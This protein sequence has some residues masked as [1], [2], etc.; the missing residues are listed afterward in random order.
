[1][2]RLRAGFASAVVVLASAALPIALVRADD[3]KGKNGAA[4]GEPGRQA[5]KLLQSYR[6]FR[7]RSGEYDRTRKEIDQQIKELEELVRIRYDMTLAVAELKACAGPSKSAQRSSAAVGDDAL[8]RELKA[9]QTQ[10]A[11]EIEQAHAQTEKVAAQLQALKDGHKGEE[12]KHESPAAARPAANAK[13][14]PAQAK[15]GSFE[16]P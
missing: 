8:G 7:E 1:M 11:T 16:Q 4:A 9:V 15:A 14:G 10:L 5:E 13:P 6:S 12:P 3:A 2:N